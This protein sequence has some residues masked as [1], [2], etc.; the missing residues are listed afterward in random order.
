M[1]FHLLMFLNREGMGSRGSSFLKDKGMKAGN[2][3]HVYSS[4]LTPFLI[5]KEGV[6]RAALGSRDEGGN[7]LSMSEC[8]GVGSI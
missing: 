2:D 5:W 1:S 4:R 3:C 7:L 8:S 6:S